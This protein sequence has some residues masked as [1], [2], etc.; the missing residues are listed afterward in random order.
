MANWDGSSKGNKL[1][2]SIFVALLRAGGTAPAY[3]LL[4]FVSLYYFLFSTGA[5][6]AISYYLHQR[7]KFSG[8]KATRLRYQNYYWFGQALIDRIVMMSGIRNRF[9]FHFDGE[10]HLHDMVAAGKGGLLLSAH[11]GNWEIAGHLLK[12]LNTKINI[13][14][15]DG[16][17]EQVKAYLDGVTGERNANLILIKDNISHIYEIMEALNNNELVCMHSDRFMEG[18]KTLASLF[19]GAPAQF[20]A[21]PFT[22]AAKLPVPVSFVFALKESATHY[23]FFATEGT[24]YRGHPEKGHPAA[25]LD[26][27]VQE[28]TDKVRRYPAQWYNYYPFWGEDKS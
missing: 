19:L 4:R 17:H 7:L 28:M 8:W 14:M 23:H 15:Y 11:I 13:V 9:S 21:G 22:I 3:F 25:I 18:N 12:R 5:N 16:E 27:F 10:Q 6:R 20:P 26:D 24:V 1:G 2:Y